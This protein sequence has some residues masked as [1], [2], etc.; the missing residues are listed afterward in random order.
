MRRHSA[1]G[2]ASGQH[3]LFETGVR[4]P[5]SVHAGMHHTHGLG[6]DGVIY[7]PL[8]KPAVE[9]LAPSDEAELAR[10]QRQGGVDRTGG[11]LE[12]ERTTTRYVGNPLR[13]VS[14]T[15]V[16]RVHGRPCKRTGGRGRT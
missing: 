7:L 2:Q 9:P 12:P 1:S 5:Q 15:A 3:V 13:L 6:L 14:Q 11:T 16:G 8:R 10:H 4:P